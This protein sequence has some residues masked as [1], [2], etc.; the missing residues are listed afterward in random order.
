M[1][2]SHISLHSLCLQDLASTWQLEMGVGHWGAFSQHNCL[3][4][5]WQGLMSFSKDAVQELDLTLSA[6]PE[7]LQGGSATEAR[8]SNEK[9]TPMGPPCLM[10]RDWGAV[11]E[12][13]LGGR[14]VMGVEKEMWL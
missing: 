13:L 3:S 4:G 1:V 5:V 12:E 6:P 8:K 14:W 7:E 2:V 11:L 10:P 9:D